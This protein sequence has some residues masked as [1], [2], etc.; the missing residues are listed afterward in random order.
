MLESF[1]GFILVLASG[2]IGKEVLLSEQPSLRLT[3]HHL[4][5]YRETLGFCA[6]LTGFLGLY[7]GLS[8]GLSHVYTP[9]YWL[10]WTSS[11]LV[12]LLVG[13]SLCFDIIATRIKTFSIKLHQCCQVSKLLID[14]KPAP[15]CWLGLSLGTWRALW[16]W[17]GY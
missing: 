3:L 12:A 5:A 13:L 16:P 1:I 15:W 4:E 11:N 7:H 10:A 17:L 9:I 2:L 6:L 14:S 8:T